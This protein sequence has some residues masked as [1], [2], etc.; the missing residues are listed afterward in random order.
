MTEDTKNSWQA[1][2]I[3]LC[4]CCFIVVGIGVWFLPQLI[5]EHD[6]DGIA[7]TASWIG[8]GVPLFIV[9]FVSWKGP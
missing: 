6:T 5:W 8:L 7:L 9:S 3:M 2:L 1:V 4:V